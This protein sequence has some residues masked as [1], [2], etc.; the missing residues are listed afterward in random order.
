MSGQN[1]AA[2]ES[3]LGIPSLDDALAT[4]VALFD[5]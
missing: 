4:Y 2:Q 5:I 1:G 3:T